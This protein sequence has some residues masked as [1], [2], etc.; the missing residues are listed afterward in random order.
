M[1]KEIRLRALKNSWQLAAAQIMSQSEKF[2]EK[3][4]LMKMRKRKFTIKRSPK[5][6][7]K[8]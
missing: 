3:E 6:W 4:S 5:V 8:T 7:R 1:C 2:S